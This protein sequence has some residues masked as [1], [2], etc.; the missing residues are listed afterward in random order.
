[1]KK[2]L[3]LLVF[4]FHT[5]TFCFGQYNWQLLSSSPQNGQ[6]QDDVFFLNEKQGWSVNG[7][8]RIYR[9]KNGGTSW[10]KVTDKP[11]TYFRCI[12]FLDSLNGFAGNIG[13]NYFPGVTDNQ[14]LYKTSDGGLNWTA[15]STI[16]GPAPTGL[17]A[18]QIIDS[19]NIVAGGRVGSPVHLLKS[20]DKG[21]TWTS[22]DMSSECEMIVDVHFFSPDTGFVFCGTNSNVQFSS[23]SVLYTTD[24]GLSFTKVFESSRN[25]ELCW[26][27]SFPSRNVGYFT[28]L[29]YAPNSTQRFIAKTTDGGLTWT[30]NQFANN[31]NKAFGIGFLND[32]T[33]WVGTDQGG[34]QTTN[35]GETWTTKNIGQFAN[36]IRVLPNGTAFAIGLRIYKLNRVVSGNETIISQKNEEFRAYPNP[37]SGILMLEMNSKKAGPVK[38]ELI[39]LNGKKV[40]SLFD[41]FVERGKN[42]MSFHPGR[43]N[44]QV[45]YLRIHSPDGVKVL[46]VNILP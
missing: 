18:I 5:L 31:G 44:K 25:F 2:I 32:S 41:G 40:K 13:P 22:I 12:G 35:G 21:Q 39:D 11:G 14:P 1:M 10:T 34:W 23:A 46:P 43:E 4:W 7:S 29:S 20:A 9:T 45:V 16:S 27:A 30:E 33:G 19:L 42:K 28:I 24:G 37:T 26:K 38:I 8:G 3:L 36:K 15:V 6:K 17:C